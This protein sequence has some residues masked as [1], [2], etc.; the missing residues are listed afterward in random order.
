MWSWMEAFNR[1]IHRLIVSLQ[2]S[3]HRITKIWKEKLKKFLVSGQFCAIIVFLWNEK[4][5][6][7]NQKRE[8]RKTVTSF[9]VL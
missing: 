5:S 1:F 7:Q 8:E 9:P 6:E 4:I 2:I 3:S